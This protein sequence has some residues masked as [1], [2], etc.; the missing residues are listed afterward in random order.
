MVFSDLSIEQDNFFEIELRVVLFPEVFNELLIVF[1]SLL[2]KVWLVPYLLRNKVFLELGLLVFIAPL[3]YPVDKSPD[4]FEDHAVHY[5][6]LH[7]SAE[8]GF[9]HFVHLQVDPHKLSVRVEECL[10]LTQQHVVIGL[11]SLSDLPSLVGSCREFLFLKE[12]RVLHHFTMDFILNNEH[13]V[14]E[15]ARNQIIWV[16]Y[17]MESIGELLIV[18]KEV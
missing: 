12:V 18:L 2:W 15:W 7:Y 1:N 4:R 9:A 11:T 3:H 5:L 6:E 13:E 14:L 16:K 10:K 8:A 17:L